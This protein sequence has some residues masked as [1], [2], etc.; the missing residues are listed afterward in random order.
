MP[1]LLPCCLFRPGWSSSCLRGPQTSE[2]LPTGHK[3]APEI[4][5][6]CAWQAWEE[7]AIHAESAISLLHGLPIVCYTGVLVPA[8]SFKDHALD[9]QWC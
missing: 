9:Q 7:Q 2:R 5:Q 4:S 6:S 1:G 3:S 8:M